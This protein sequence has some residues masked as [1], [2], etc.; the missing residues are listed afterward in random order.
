M[1]L[2][3]EKICNMQYNFSLL[4]FDIIS[5]PA[6]QTINIPQ[7]KHDLKKFTRVE[8]SIMTHFHA[9]SDDRLLKSVEQVFP[10]PLNRQ[11]KTMLTG[12]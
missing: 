2:N 8:V 4:P 7:T 1:K 10:I 9:V 6:M 5:L 3:D 11:L 12:Q